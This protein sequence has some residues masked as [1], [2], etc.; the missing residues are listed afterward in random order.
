LASLLFATFAM[1]SVN[2]P[3]GGRIALNGGGLNLG[4]TDATVSGNLQLGSG[5]ITDGRNVRI[6]AGSVDAGAGAITLGGNWVNQGSFSAGSSLVSIVDACAPAA[7]FSG[8]TTFY[9]LSLLSTIG[10]RIAISPGETQT[11]LHALTIHGSLANPIQIQSGVPGRPSFLS[12]APG[13]TQDISHVGV[14]DNWATGQALAPGL[15]N[16]G[17]AGNSL[18]WFGVS[19]NGIRPIPALGPWGLALL[20]LLIGVFGW[21]FRTGSAHTFSRKTA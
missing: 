3:A 20:T 1:A 15:F 2:I 10:K 21:V 19:L 4:C 11:V 18:G 17:G 14:S 9:D 5:A 7:T 6:L 12:L 13:G 8:P 16:E